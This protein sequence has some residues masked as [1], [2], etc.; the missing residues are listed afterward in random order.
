[1]TGLEAKVEIVGNQIINEQI[2]A[3]KQ[4]LKPLYLRKLAQ[5]ETNQRLEE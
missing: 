3:S 2:N 5:I 1:M 4:E